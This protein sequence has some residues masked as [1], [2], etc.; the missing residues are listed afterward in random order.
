MGELRKNWTR[1]PRWG[2]WSG[3]AHYA[4][5]LRTLRAAQRTPAYTR[6][7]PTLA[8]TLTWPQAFGSR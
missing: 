7:Y 8:G 3:E 6:R 5:Q 2:E 4:V 1:V